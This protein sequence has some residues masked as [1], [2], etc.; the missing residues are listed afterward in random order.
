MVTACCEQADSKRQS[1]SVTCDN[2][3]DCSDKLAKASSEQAKL[4]TTDRL[5]TRKIAVIGNGIA[6][7]AAALNLDMTFRPVRVYGSPS[8]WSTL[9]G[10][11]Q[12]WQT[13]LKGPFEEANLKDPATFIEG[14]RPIRIPR[15]AVI[16]ANLEG[17]VRA[18]ADYLE[19]GPVTVN[20][21]DDGSWTIVD[22]HGH[23]EIVTGPLIVGTG[24]LRPLRITDMIPG[25]QTLNVRRALVNKELLTTGDN[26]LS[27]SDPPGKNGEVVGIAGKGGNSADCVI[28]I[29]EARPQP[30]GHIAKEVVIWGGLPDLSLRQTTAYKE[31]EKVYDKRIC[32]VD[33]Y[34]TKIE[35][36]DGQIKINS[37]SKPHCID[38]DGKSTAEIAPTVKSFVE[39]LGRYEGDPPPEVVSAARRRKVTYIPL[40]E[41]TTNALIAIEVRFEGDN[42]GWPPMYLIGAAATWIPPGVEISDSDLQ[43]Y[44]DG[45]EMTHRAVNAGGT[46]NSE[47]PPQGFAV[48]A[49]MG[50]NLARLINNKA[51][52]P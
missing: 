28:R 45:L 31:L 34:V 48:A 10:L 4:L 11:P 1:V 6:G 29:L 46:A 42:N 25:R 49:F 14:S 40:V 44:L 27:S 39:S 36:T 43:K 12:V 13:S 9:Q 22:V 52:H 37:N 38:K 17:L 26:C 16:A 30:T 20:R 35:Y 2:F 32:R 19:T 8:F 21:R 50:S 41:N 23:K 7:T 3:K 5:S 51:S 18:Q 15:E 33:G 24:L 47:N